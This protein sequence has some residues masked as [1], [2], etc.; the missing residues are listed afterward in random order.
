MKIIESTD[1][2]LIISD[3]KTDVKI[4]EIAN[5]QLGINLIFALSSL[6]FLPNL[7]LFVPIVDLPTKIYISMCFSINLT[8]AIVFYFKNIKHKGILSFLCSSLAIYFI[9]IVGVLLLG[10]V[11]LN[12]STVYL[13]FDNNEGILTVKKLK[14]LFWNFSRQYPLNEILEAD[15]RKVTLYYGSGCF[16]E[17]DAIRITRRFK[18]SNLILWIGLFQ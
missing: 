6:L 2:R 16:S 1:R 7:N 10:G 5:T 3:E 11:L 8:L 15:L 12:P 13:A 18:K 17:V 14:F 4:G 9:P